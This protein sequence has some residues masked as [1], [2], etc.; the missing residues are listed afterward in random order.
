LKP[1]DIFGSP[2]AARE[3]VEPIRQALGDDRMPFS[4]RTA[5]LRGALLAI[6][7]G[8]PNPRALAHKTLNEEHA[9]QQAEYRQQPRGAVDAE[10]EQWRKVPLADYRREV[11]RL[12]A[13]LDDADT[14][15]GRLRYE[16]E[17]LRQQLRG[18]V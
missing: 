11:E 1:S 7:S 4:E 15:N 12:R 14:A 16:L 17:E 9:D 18:A 2:E 10:L 3:A 5:K 8:H 6:S 13:E